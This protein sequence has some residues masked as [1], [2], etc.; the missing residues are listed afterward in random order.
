[1][2]QNIYIALVDDWELRGT[3]AGNVTQTQVIPMQKLLELYEKYDIKCSFN[4]EIMQQL[5][6]IKYQKKYLELSEQV[7]AWDNAVLD[8]YRR[9]NDI[10]LHIHPQWFEAGY[11]NGDWE[12]SENW[13]ITKYPEDEVRKMFTEGISYLKKLLKNESRP[14][15]L[16]AF[17]SGAW[18]LAPS[19]FMLDLIAE[20]GIVFDMSMVS[21]VKY[22]T[23]HILLDYTELEEGFL[24]YYPNMRDARK[25][26]DKN[27]PVICVPT[28]SFMCY[29]WRRLTSYIKKILAYPPP[30]C[31][32]CR[33]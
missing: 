12:L 13:D 27:E 31:K 18:A 22:D 21:G 32:E 30:A 16:V 5:T 4:V 24:P 25:L 15:K 29:G 10:Q 7:Q 2:Q 23:N 33:T 1:M 20:H 28:F 19:D 17:R 8:A 11:E 3:G 9:G 14:L 26:S 6:M